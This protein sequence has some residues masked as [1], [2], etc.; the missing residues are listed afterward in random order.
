MTWEDNL[1]QKTELIE[2]EIEG[3]KITVKPMSWYQN[4]QL[5][6]KHFKAN[7]VTKQMEINTAEYTSSVLKLGVVKG[8]WPAEMK[9]AILMKLKQKV[10]D[11]LVEEITGGKTPGEELKKK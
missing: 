1:C 11:K 6:S 3:E 2:L 10:V 7:P 5:Q 9:E 4:E 8:P